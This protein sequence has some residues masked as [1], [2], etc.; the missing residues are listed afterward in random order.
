MLLLSLAFCKQWQA[1]NGNTF[2]GDRLG[3]CCWLCSH[4]PSLGMPALTLREKSNSQGQG[5]ACGVNIKKRKETFTLCPCSHLKFFTSS[6]LRMFRNKTW[7]TG[8]NGNHIT[9]IH[10][11]TQCYYFQYLSII[12]NKTNVKLQLLQKPS[13]TFQS[14]SMN[15]ALSETI[16]L[17]NLN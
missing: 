11:L 1:G 16:R 10:S 2:H 13:Q 7:V 8:K 14:F 5:Q 3:L 9:L 15:M 17:V 6:T 4:K 12:K